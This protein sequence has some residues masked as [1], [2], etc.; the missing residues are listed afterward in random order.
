VGNGAVPYL[1]VPLPVPFEIAVV[2]FELVDYR[3][4]E[5]LQWAA[6]PSRLIGET[7][8]K[9]N[10]LPS[11]SSRR[12]ALSSKSSG[13]TA[14]MRFTR[15]SRLGSSVTRPGTSSLVATHT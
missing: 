15:L 2:L 9:S 1:M 4:I 13:I 3:L 5:A 6:A 7:T 12:C 8:Q 14:L 11:S 10:E